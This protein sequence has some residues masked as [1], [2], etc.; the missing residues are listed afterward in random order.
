MKQKQKDAKKRAIIEKKK[1]AEK[2]KEAK[3]VAKMQKQQANLQNQFLSKVKKE[4][5][6]NQDNI[7]QTR[8]KQSWQKKEHTITA[9]NQEY[10]TH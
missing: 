4:K 3:K 8:N 7:R 10:K 1:I 6:D 2:E 9:T 5:L